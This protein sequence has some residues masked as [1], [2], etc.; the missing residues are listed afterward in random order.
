MK[1]DDV[2]KFFEAV[3]VMRK[4]SAHVTC[5][6]YPNGPAFNDAWCDAGDLIN[7]VE[8]AALSGVE[9]DAADFAAAVTALIDAVGAAKSAFGPFW[10]ERLPHRTVSFDGA[11]W[12][13]AILPAFVRMD[14]A[15]ERLAAFD[16]VEP[17]IRPCPDCAAEQRAV[18][19]CP[20]VH[21]FRCY[22]RRCGLSGPARDTAPAAILAFN[23]LS[24]SAV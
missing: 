2:K 8:K 16:E 24:C 18:G 11:L 3:R 15:L 5:S 21:G 1:A 6:V 10:H 22:C 9:D 13:K 17:P 20:Q 19:F 14:A 4:Q 12:Q 7:E 23:G